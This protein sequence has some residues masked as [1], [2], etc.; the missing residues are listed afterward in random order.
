MSSKLELEINEYVDKEEED[1]VNEEVDVSQ[2]SGGEDQNIEDNVHYV[3]NIDSDKVVDSHENINNENTHYKSGEA[4]HDIEDGVHQEEHNV[5]SE[6]VEVDNKNAEEVV[7]EQNIDDVEDDNIVEN[8]NA[9]EKVNVKMEVDRIELN[10]NDDSELVED[11][12]NAFK[13]DFRF[14][15]IENN[16][17]Q[18]KNLNKTKIKQQ[19]QQE[20][21]RGPR[22]RRRRGKPMLFH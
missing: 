12:E 15:S 3:E 19:Q 17:I 21:F 7:S 5:D 16:N 9:Y 2:E 18:N 1:E 11:L 10:N 6:I 4:K 13:K 8:Y 22:R 20:I 14:A